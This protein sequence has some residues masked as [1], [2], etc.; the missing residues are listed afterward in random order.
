[1]EYCSS[2]T[3]ILQEESMYKNNTKK[4]KFIEADLGEYAYCDFL[5]KEHAVRAKRFVQTLE[6]YQ[7]TPLVSLDSLASR[8]GVRKI[9]V[10][11]ESKRMG[12]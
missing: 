10:K 4:C 9:Y 8:F 7:A 1:M 2:L 5:T 12:L 6:D 11:D 3:I